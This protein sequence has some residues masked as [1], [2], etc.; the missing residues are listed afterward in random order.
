MLTETIS[1]RRKDT[2]TPMCEILLCTRDMGNSGNLAVDSKAPKQGDVI[3][4]HPDGW[5]WGD[6]ELGVAVPGNPNGKHPFFRVIKIPNVTE[7]QAA[8]MLT[9]ELDVDPQNPSPYLQYRGRFLDKSKIPAGALRTYVLDDLRAQQTISIPHTA[10]QL[11]TIVTVR[12][13]VPF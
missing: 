9:R 7:A 11:N 2:R 13:P 6:C 12:T 10:A 5:T 3:D 4:V 1:K 8:N